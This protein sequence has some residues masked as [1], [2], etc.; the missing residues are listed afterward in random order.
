MNLSS[1]TTWQVFRQAFWKSTWLLLNTLELAQHLVQVLIINNNYKRYHPRFQVVAAL[2]S[3]PMTSTDLKELL[4]FQVFVICSI[5]L[6]IVIITHHPTTTTV[7]TKVWCHFNTNCP[8]WWGSLQMVI[9]HK[10]PRLHSRLLIPSEQ[11][12][13]HDGRPQKR[14][15]T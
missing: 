3:G 13:P 2:S 4:W 12:C 5:I 7:I 1:P 6:R 15:A 11:S 8:L 9:I 10:N 14:A